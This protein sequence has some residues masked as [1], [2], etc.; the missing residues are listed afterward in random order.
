MVWPFNSNASLIRSRHAERDALIEEARKILSEQYTPNNASI[1]TSILSSNIE[2]LVKGIEQKKWTST[3]IV[4]T[5]IRQAIIA[6]EQTN[7]LTEVNFQQALERAEELDNEFAKNGKLVGPLH[8]IPF[9]LKDQ[10]HLQGK[11]SAT[12]YSEWLKKEPQSESAAIARIAF[13][14]GGVCIAKTNVPQT[15]LNFECRNPAW[16]QTTNPYSS[17]HTCGGSSG[18]EAALLSIGG[19]AF[20]IGSDIGGSL[21][22][23]TS[24]CG[25]YALK[26]TNGRTWP[27]AGSIEFGPS[28]TPIKSVA[29]PMCRSVQDLDLLVRL[30]TK[31]M[32]PPMN[33]IEERAVSFRDVQRSYGMEILPYMPLQESWLD[34]L[35]AAEKRSK[36]GGEKTIRIGWYAC[37]GYIKQTPVSL[38]SMEIVT[39]ALRNHVDT[40]N[41][42]GVNIELIELQ[43]SELQSFDTFKTFVG[44]TSITRYDFLKR[45]LGADWIDRALWVALILPNHSFIRAL[46]GSIARWVLRDP[47]PSQFLNNIANDSARKFVEHEHQ[48]ERLVK[49]FEKRVWNSHNLDAIVCPVQAT[50]ALPHYGS[51]LLAPLASATILYNVLRNPATVVP[52]TRVDKNLD[53]VKS[54]ASVKQKWNGQ[55][56]EKKTS[57]M[58]ASD[59]AKRFNAK[60]SHGLP[61]A[62]QVVT[63]EFEDEKAVGFA[64]LLDDALAKRDSAHRKEFGP[65]AW[66]RWNTKNDLNK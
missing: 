11:R 27:R 23:P 28:P 13:S 61:F 57:N 25:I 49:D 42:K 24:Y 62:V 51:T 65:G 6:H 35:Q 32:N 38:R 18:G 10:Y 31:T 19:S 33:E 9:S 16:G 55:K 45:H 48:R 26:T 40:S 41:N 58:V 14:L 5:F 37:D 66:Q 43:P 63:R 15:M 46:I 21:R 39:D 17:A 54:S 44:L 59:L 4:Q 29:G 3:I 50:S 30:F 56:D 53:D 1:S 47:Y 2:D 8:G 12:G 34:P 22:I 7:C 36:S 60:D 64:R 52:V 20:G